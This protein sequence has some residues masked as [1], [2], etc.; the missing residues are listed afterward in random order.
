VVR[1]NLRARPQTPAETRPGNEGDRTTSILDE[2]TRSGSR[3][4][5]KHAGGDKQPTAAGKTDRRQFEHAVRR[6]KGEQQ[7]KNLLALIET[8]HRADADAVH[9]K[10]EHR[11]DPAGDTPGEGKKRHLHIV[12]HNARCHDR[13]QH[14]GI[15][16][17]A[18]S[19]LCARHAVVG[20]LQHRRTDELSRDGRLHDH[21]P[22]RNRHR[23]EQH[24]RRD[25]HRTPR[26]AN[27]SGHGA[28]Q[29]PEHRRQGEG[30]TAIQQVVGARHEPVEVEHVVTR[31]AGCGGTQTRQVSGQDPVLRHEFANAL[32]AERRETALL[33][34]AQQGRKGR[35]AWRVGR[36]DG[37]SFARGAF[38]VSGGD[39]LCA[40]RDFAVVQSH[41][42]HN[43]TV[44]C[45]RGCAPVQCSRAPWRIAR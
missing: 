31:P 37:K 41:E 25:R 27:L 12:R 30:L 17:V 39:T 21:R 5:Q 9:D 26:A 1:Q 13:A 14:L 29:I 10:Q 45:R 20:A 23:S 36:D 3:A 18:R 2:R 33:R 16:D 35:P 28:K 40:R 11:E 19:G 15:G 4:R 7:R 34:L 32:L 6:N 38:V 24:Q 8:H 22:R 42:S 43:D 44:R